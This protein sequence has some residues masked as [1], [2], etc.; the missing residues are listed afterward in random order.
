MLLP[1]IKAGVRGL[2]I[3][4]YVDLAGH[5]NGHGVPPDRGTLVLFL[6]EQAID[7]SSALL[8]IGASGGR[9]LRVNSAKLTSNRLDIG[10]SALQT[11]NT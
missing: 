4:R 5:D 10:S 3:G 11:Q 9:Q 8:P 7:A 2:G 1:K 6:E